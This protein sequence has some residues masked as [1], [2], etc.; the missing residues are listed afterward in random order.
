MKEDDF[1]H[2]V[3]EH[4]R[5]L[6]AYTPGKPLRDAERETGVDC[7]KLASNENPFGPSPLA[8]EAMRAAA[9][10]SN[11]YPDNE[12]SELRRRLAERHRVSPEQILIT[13][14]STQLIDI[15][16]RT[17]LR[18]GLNAVTSERSFIVYPIMVK[19]AG[20]AL[21]QAPMRGDTYDLDALLAAIDSQTRVVL[22]SNPN[23]PT[24][25]MFDAAAADRFIEKV[26][27]DIVV[28]LDEAY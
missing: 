20:A 22:I 14:G 2:L 25:T 13:A 23:N 12:V 24:G 4:I 11:F 10:R 15:I 8:V 1:D 19:A 18:A 7:I 21:R 3:P 9:G 16:A 5:A 27:P 6:A 26:P 17:L 28:V